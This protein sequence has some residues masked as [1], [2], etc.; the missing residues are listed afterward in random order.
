M[1][2]E[3]VNFINRYKQ[4]FNQVF[5]GMSNPDILV[6]EKKEIKRSINQIRPKSRSNFSS[7]LETTHSTS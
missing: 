4:A 2:K 5:I 6:K 7:G 1:E 3:D